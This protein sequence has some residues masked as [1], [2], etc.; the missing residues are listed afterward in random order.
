MQL[1]WI[2]K[3]TP[4]GRQCLACLNPLSF[5]GSANLTAIF[6]SWVSN[7]WNRGPLFVF[8]RT[9]FLLSLPDRNRLLGNGGCLFL[10]YAGTVTE[11]IWDE[12]S[13]DCSFRVSQ[14][15]SMKPLA[16]SGPL[17]PSLC[18]VCPSFLCHFPPILSKEIEHCFQKMGSD[19]RCK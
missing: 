5:P 6:L 19:R 3:H 15:Q 17:P 9:S 2:C 16:F 14:G 1:S 11:D 12:R 7:F 8:E 13:R 4:G 10:L 18:T